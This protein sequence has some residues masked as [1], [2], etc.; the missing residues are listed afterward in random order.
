[1]PAPWNPPMLELRDLHTTAH[2]REKVLQSLDYRRKCSTGLKRS[3]GI[4][5]TRTLYWLLELWDNPPYCGLPRKLAQ[6]LSPCSLGLVWFMQLLRGRRGKRKQPRLSGLQ[7]V[8]FLQFR[9]GVKPRHCRSGLGL[10]WAVGSEDDTGNHCAFRTDNNYAQSQNEV[11]HTTSGCM[12][13]GIFG[14]VYS[15]TI[16]ITL[17]LTCSTI[18]ITLKLASC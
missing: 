8:Y 15:S 6:P 3:L 4:I 11:I 5:S 14:V 18:N 1:M 2:S 7:L 10:T 16:N 12:H 13:T 9:I 17:K